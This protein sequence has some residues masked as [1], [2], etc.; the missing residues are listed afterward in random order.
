ML[1]AVQMSVLPKVIETP[2][3]AAVAKDGIQL[4]AVCRVT[5]RTNLQQFVGGATLGGLA[6]VFRRSLVEIAK[7]V[8]VLVRHHRPLGG[9]GRRERRG[10]TQ[11]QRFAIEQC[12]IV[13]LRPFHLDKAPQGRCRAGHG[14]ALRKQT[15]VA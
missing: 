9:A 15:V 6:N 2:K 3:I 8:T 5:V 1:E 13:V 11:R 12:R 10:A 4:I 14:P 7:H